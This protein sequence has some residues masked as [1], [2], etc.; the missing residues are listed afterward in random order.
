M[1]LESRS[2]FAA[3]SQYRNR[4]AREAET[5]S[6][7]PFARKPATPGSGRLGVSYWTPEM[8]KKATGVGYCLYKDG[9]LPV[10]PLGIYTT[11]DLHASM[12]Y[13]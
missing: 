2:P 9:A 7:K 3:Y 5:G 4:L 13:R 12:P 10:T 6:A 8:Q 11:L 1:Y